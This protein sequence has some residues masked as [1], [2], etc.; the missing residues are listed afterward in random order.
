MEILQR[1]ER[2]PLTRVQIGLLFAGGLGY[3]FD[4]MDGAVIAFILPAVT[5]LWGLS[6]GQT[7]LLGSSLLI[8]YLFGAFL[9][10]TL[11]DLIG[12]KRI[13]MYALAIYCTATLIA[14]ASPSW[15]FLFVMRVLAGFG[16]GAESAII[17]PFLAEFIP[18]KVRGVLVGSLAGFFSFGYVGAALL[19]RFI[20]PTSDNGWRIVQVITALPIL[21]LLWWRRSIPESPRWLIERGRADEAEQVVASL[22][23]RVAR[24]VSGPLPPPDSVPLPAVPARTGG[25][26][27]RNLA[28]L[29]GR[30]MAR[31]TAMVWILWFAITFA[32]YGFFTWIPSLLVRLGFNITQSFDYSLII[33]VAQIP[34]YYSAAFISE[35]ID[36]KWTITTYLVGGAISALLLANARDGTLITA[37]G[38]LLSFFMN[39]TYAGLYSYTPEVYPTAFRATGMGVAS[40]V[41]RIGGIAAP[42]IIGFTFGAIGFGGVFTLTTAVLAAAALAVVVVGVSTAG[43][44]LEQITAE[45]LGRAS[46]RAGGVVARG[47]GA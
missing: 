8:G 3:T 34:G 4:A 1:L 19:G 41:G 36:R 45:E 47:T 43:K 17:A 32:Y 25:S 37:T 24:H 31:T 46:P 38:A 2:L 20:V 12:R 22:E 21:L 18:S 23:Q 29:W 40:A 42:L 7:G 11:G 44:T 26:F 28:A 16:T 9:A 35:K 33:Y 10:G 6:S 27:G 5:A 13:M 39:G 14:A 15:E 30:T